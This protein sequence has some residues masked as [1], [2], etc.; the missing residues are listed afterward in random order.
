MSISSRATKRDPCVKIAMK[1]EIDDAQNFRHARPS[2]P[3][4]CKGRAMNT[5]DDQCEKYPLKN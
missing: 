2:A 3:Y 4:D 5:Q 1:K